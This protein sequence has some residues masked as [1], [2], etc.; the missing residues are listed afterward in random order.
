MWL[1]L[2][3]W[4][5]SGAWF[6]TAPTAGRIEALV[7][8]IACAG[9]PGVMLLK[10]TQNYLQTPSTDIDGGTGEPSVES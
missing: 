3:P 7:G 4:A 8:F 10:M 5:L 9:L 2:G 1:V 6:L